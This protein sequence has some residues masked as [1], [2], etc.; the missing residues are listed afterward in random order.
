MRRS[1]VMT[2]IIEVA[3]LAEVSVTTV[4]HVINETRFVAPETRARVL[5]AMQEL[6]YRPNSLARSLRVGSTLTLGLILPDSAN[7]YFA[8]IGREIEAAAFN[9][10]FNVILCNSEGDDI[11]EKH[12]ISVL[13]N[14]QV[15]GI[16]FV[17]AGGNSDVVERLIA[18]QRPFV[19]VDRDL[20]DAPAD[21]VLV[22]NYQGAYLATRFL[23]ELG[24]RR[25]ACISGPLAVSSSSRR[26]NGYRQALE[27]FHVPY[28]AALVIPGDFHA[29]AGYEAV[30]ALLHIPQPP[31]AF[32]ACNDLMGYGALK[33]LHEAGKRIPQE[34]MVIGFDD[35]ELSSF[36]YPS[37]TTVHQPKDLI[38]RRT[39][40]ILIERIHDHTRPFVKEVIPVTLKIRESTGGAV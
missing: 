40:E 1:S 34:A 16:I 35:I 37:L 10:G 3:K 20:P 27:E 17:S 28:D 14:R 15:D 39:V 13:T 7:P 12:Y 9:S 6:G 11:K 24:H 2:T 8:E 36:V 32:F 33:A 30:N 5:Q 4:S 38:G 19:V 26:V 18:T 22:D 21:T 23:L 29:Q 31:S 25:I